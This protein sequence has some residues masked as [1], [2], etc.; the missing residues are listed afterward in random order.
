MHRFLIVISGRHYSVPA[1][2]HS[3]AVDH[4]R[5]A[6]TISGSHPI[7]PQ[8]TNTESMST[9][10]TLTTE[11]CQKS[12]A[13]SVDNET[14]SGCLYIP[15]HA[16]KESPHLPHY[17]YKLH[18]ELDD[19]EAYSVQSPTEGQHSGVATLHHDQPP[20]NASHPS[21]YSTSESNLPQ[22]SGFSKP[23]IH[24]KIYHSSVPFTAESSSASSSIL[25]IS[26]EAIANSAWQFSSNPSSS[27]VSQENILNSSRSDIMESKINVVQ[28][29]RYQSRLSQPTPI[30]GPHN[31]PLNWYQT[32]LTS[33]PP[34]EYEQWCPGI[35]EG[36]SISMHQ[37]SIQ[38]VV[39]IPMNRSRSQ[40]YHRPTYNLYGQ[41]H[42]FSLA[43]HPYQTSAAFDPRLRAQFGITPEE[44]N[45]V[46]QQYI[47]YQGPQNQHCG[48]FSNEG[49]QPEYHMHMA[50]TQCRLPSMYYA[51]VEQRKTMSS[52]ETSG[53]GV[54]MRGWGSDEYEEKNSSKVINVK[55]GKS[56][57]QQQ[58][59]LL[60]SV[61]T[62]PEV[63]NPD[64]GPGCATTRERATQN[65]RSP[66]EVATNQMNMSQPQPV[67][68]EYRSDHYSSMTHE[69]VPSLDTYSNTST[70]RGPK[71]MSR[72]SSTGNAS[73]NNTSEHNLGSMATLTSSFS[74]ASL[75]SPLST[76][77]RGSIKNTQHHF[78]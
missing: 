27:N 68:L 71:H 66:R 58:A 53:A 67:T 64:L 14:A 61:N 37:P 50:H 78:S 13:L 9:E 16:G 45:F 74:Q 30:R 26:P 55:H 76:R 17:W 5:R 3:S 21:S 54:A 29:H 72:S 43:P 19:T 28:Q 31:Q 18:S 38:P 10:S 40:D 47:P 69:S 12:H 63:H 52:D 51:P 32:S 33:L 23:E 36:T 39:P 11:A 59:H 42:R 22:N 1:K 2:S 57:L 25:E 65:L 44:P 4:E 73:V 77:S 6:N 41:R 20:N 15:N 56:A 8:A 46:P 35:P 48:Q 70:K 7:T 24:H 62:V 75:N 34:P 60:P 49:Y